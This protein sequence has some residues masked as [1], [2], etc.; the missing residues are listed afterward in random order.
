MDYNDSEDLHESQEAINYADHT[1]IETEYVKKSTIAF[2]FILGTLCITINLIAIIRPLLEWRE[3]QNSP[4][5][6]QFTLLLP[7]GSPYTPPE[8]ER[9]YFR[10]YAESAILFSIP[11]GLSGLL[12]FWIGYRYL[13]KRNNYIKSKKEHH[14]K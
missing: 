6:T 13:R 12:S 7:D 8:T 4:K 5:T 1:L 10:D 11:F 14:I 2:Y 9:D 3:M